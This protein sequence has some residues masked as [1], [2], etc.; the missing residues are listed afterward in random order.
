[1]VDP[2]GAVIPNAT[3]IATNGNGTEKTVTSNAQGEYTITGLPAGTYT[4]RVNAATF[5]PYENTEVAVTAGRRE[6]LIVTLTV[7]IAAETV[8]VG[9]EQPVSSEPDNNADATV[10]R[11]RDLEALPEDPEELASAL[12]ALAGSSAGPNGGQLFIDGF[13]GGRV[14]PREAIREV[15]INQ[16]PFSAEFDRLGFGRIE[17]LTRPG[18]ERLRGQAFF[19]FGDESLNSRNPF[20]DNKPSSQIRNYGGNITG[21]IIKNK[22]SYFFDFNRRE[23][24]DNAIINADILD[25]G[26]NIVPFQQAIL[27][28]RRRLS[29]SPR[30]DYQINSRNTLVARYTFERDE[31]ENQG[32]SETSLPSRAFNSGETEHTLQLTNT[33]I[34]S[35]TIVN[36]TRFQYIRERQTSEGNSLPTIIAAQDFALGGS[37]VGLGF[38]NEDRF[39]LQNYTSWSVGRH[40]FKAGVRLRHVNL[41]D[42]SENNFGGTFIFQGIP[43]I[44]GVTA[45]IRLVNG[46]LE[47]RSLSAVEQ[48]RERI[49]GNTDPRFLPNQ[50]S[51]ATGEPLAD[52]SQTDVGIFFLDD[53]RVSPALTLSFGFRY[54]NQTN[55]SSNFNFAPRFG[56]AWSPGAGGA[57]QPKTV[58]RGGFGIFY[59]RFSDNLVLNAERLNGTGQ[60]EYLVSSNDTINPVISRQLL[61]QAQ[62][63]ANGVSN[64]PTPAQLAVFAPQSNLRLIA[65]DLQ[66]PYTM[67][68]IISVERQLPFWNATLSAT[69]IAARTNNL[70]RSRNTNAPVCSTP[71]ACP[72][73]A[74]RPDL[75]RNRIDVYE[76]TGRFD[77]H[78]LVIGF[79]T[80]L[81]PRFSIFSNY[82]LGSARSDADGAGSFP[83]YSYDLSGEYSRAAFDVRHNFFFGSSITMPWNIRVNPL[84]IASSGRPFNI[85]TGDDSNKDSLFTERPT[86]AALNASCQELGLNK[87]YCDISDIS[88]PSAII[89]R[90]YGQ[91]PAFLNVNLNVFKTFGFG[92]SANAAAAQGQQGG[93]QQP[94]IPGVG[95]GRGGRG[96]QGGGGGRGGQGGGGGFGGLF[97]GGDTDK[98]YNLTLGVQIANL[99]NRTNLSTPVG[100]LASNR[101]GQ[102]LNTAGGFG[103]GG[104]GGNIGN[105]RI[106]LQ[107]RF[108]F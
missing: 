105:R 57:R 46:T 18:A 30:L 55:I 25:N 100:N 33:A 15:R 38:N 84:I 79:N 80:R 37:N 87:S 99:L 92:K 75:T 83:L 45:P 59:E 68:G 106:E 78:Q 42:F 103:F 76:S 93:G 89:P 54:E 77:Q 40:S 43:Y 49:L 9:G 1:V 13:T 82:R 22:A 16:N 91:G 47:T 21:P 70:L 104:G 53:W 66:T 63:T 72:Q 7:E 34:L 88:D 48:Y 5:A 52:I 27:T 12:Q 10:L 69:Y 96:G 39:E 58:I 28:P 6:E 94:G 2:N 56:F 11:G 95:G 97:G 8:T 107:L 98:P 108:S 85:I 26:L 51:L 31:F 4:V 61:A 32:L 50:F 23:A 62:F 17:I 73:N 102:S 60:L 36:E 86:F 29:F 44:E 14:P 90:N 64:V 67:Q 20:A 35:P 41:K 19:N 24:D 74:L 81:N 71:L 65:D 3:V 101:F